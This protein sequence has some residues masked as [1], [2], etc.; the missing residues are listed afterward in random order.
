VN[1]IVKL[2]ILGLL[3][4]GLFNFTNSQNEIKIWKEFVSA[5]MNDHITIDKIRPVEDSWKEPMLRWLKQI[6]ENYKSLEELEQDPEAFRVNNK[7]H[8]IVPL[9][10]GESSRD[11]IFTFIIEGEEWY[12]HLL[13]GMFIMF[14]KM[15]SLPTTEFPVMSENKKTWQRE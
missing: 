11:M 10:R 2:L 1:K 5:L 13:E 14:N 3:V 6:K 7:V 15:P 8:F 4:L 9:T 12:F